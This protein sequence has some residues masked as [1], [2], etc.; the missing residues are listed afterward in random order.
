MPLSQCKH[1]QQVNFP[2]HELWLERQNTESCSKGSRANVVIAGC[3]LS[4]QCATTMMRA[5]SQRTSQCQ[6]TDER[7]VKYV[8]MNV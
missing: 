4:H 2:E 7:F 1:H 8:A 5:A 6:E 3:E